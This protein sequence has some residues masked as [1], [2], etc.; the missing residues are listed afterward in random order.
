MARSIKKLFKWIKTHLAARVA[1]EGGQQFMVIEVEDR[2]Y[3]LQFTSDG[4][5]FTVLVKAPADWAPRVR[6]VLLVF[7]FR[8]LYLV[9]F[10]RDGRWL[11]YND[12]YLIGSGADVPPP[13]GIGWASRVGRLVPNGQRSTHPWQ[14]EHQRRRCQAGPASLRQSDSQ[15]GCATTCLYSASSRQSRSRIIPSSAG[16]LTS[17]IGRHCASACAEAQQRPFL[18]TVSTPT[19][20]W[21]RCC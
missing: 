15:S 8:D 21:C 2:Q 19:R 14:P 7:S 13:S 11:L 4:G 5:F 1:A 17:M 12:A 10:F 3:T 9:G 6:D 20:F 18:V 16:V